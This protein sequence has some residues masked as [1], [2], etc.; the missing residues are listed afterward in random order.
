MLQKSSVKIVFDYFFSGYSAFSYTI[1]IGV[2][3]NIV[4][5]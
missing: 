5:E 2:N 3:Q 1:N 4:N